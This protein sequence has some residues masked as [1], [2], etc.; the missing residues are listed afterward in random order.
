MGLNVF[1]LFVGLGLG[2]GSLAL[3]AALATGFP[4]A[5]IGFGLVALIAAALAVPNFATEI[6]DHRPA[7]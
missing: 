7:V 3:R 1:T 5:L 6:A 2:L 4:P